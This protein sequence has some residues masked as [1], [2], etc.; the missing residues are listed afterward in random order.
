MCKRGGE[1][2]GDLE[3]PTAAKRRPM[4]LPIPIGNNMAKCLFCDSG[5][6]EAQSINIVSAAPA[7]IER[8]GCGTWAWKR[9][10][11]FTLGLLL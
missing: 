7:Y 6:G 3:R 1:I 8:A 10:Y 4:A 2:L 9:R 5:N 11:L